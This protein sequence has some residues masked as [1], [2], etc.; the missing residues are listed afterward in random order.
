METRDE[1]R[2]S[3]DHLAGIEAALSVIAGHLAGIEATLAVIA[4]TSVEALDFVK[5]KMQAYTEKKRLTVVKTDGEAPGD[6]G[7]DP[8]KAGG[9]VAR[10]R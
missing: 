6:D 4:A 8:P 1:D 7:E 9:K 3:H 5:R 2:V 10:D